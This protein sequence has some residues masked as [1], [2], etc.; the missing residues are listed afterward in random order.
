MY[1]PILPSLL[2]FSHLNENKF[3]KAAGRSVIS[4][5]YVQ[6][7]LLYHLFLFLE[8]LLALLLYLSHLPFMMQI[9]QNR[10]SAHASFI[11]AVATEAE[12]TIT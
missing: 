4:H 5:Q 1:G 9:W 6:Y 2:H 8:V 10:E 7:M 3:K 12:A 11:M